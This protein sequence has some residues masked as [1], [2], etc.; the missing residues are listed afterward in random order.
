MQRTP[1]HGLGRRWRSWPQIIE[2]KQHTI[3]QTNAR[4]RGLPRDELPVRPKIPG[5]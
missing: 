2:F 4:I 5:K 3:S 1:I